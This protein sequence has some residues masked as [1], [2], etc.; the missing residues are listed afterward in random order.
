M[1]PGLQA[2]AFTFGN[3]QKREADFPLKQ[4]GMIECQPSF[5]PDFMLKVKPG[6]INT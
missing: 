6:S 2:A 4:R 5:G 1:L 3:M